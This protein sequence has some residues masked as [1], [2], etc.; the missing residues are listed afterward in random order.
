MSTSRTCDQRT[1]Q[2]L[3]AEC[4]FVLLLCTLYLVAM[5]FVARWGLSITPDGA[6]DLVGYLQ[7]WAVAIPAASAPY[8]VL[9]AIASIVGA[10]RGD[11][12]ASINSALN[13]SVPVGA[14][15]GIGGGILIAGYFGVIT[16]G[17][18]VAGWL[19]MYGVIV[20]IVVGSLAAA[21]VLFIGG[22]A[23]IGRL[24]ARRHG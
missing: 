6:R 19:G 10:L 7:V 5:F 22:G 2:A 24:V 3:G 17:P 18:A 16:Y 20:G 23:L 8:A 21:V 14:A 9:I 12:S 1:A 4:G 15:I 11:I 13:K